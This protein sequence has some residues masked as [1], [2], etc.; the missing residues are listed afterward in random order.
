MLMMMSWYR[1]YVGC[2]GPQALG[3]LRGDCE[4]TGTDAGTVHPRGQRHRSTGRR[5]HLAD[6]P[7]KLRLQF[8]MSAGK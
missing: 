6:R 2:I 7:R 8:R 4:K 5:L 3:A 1:S